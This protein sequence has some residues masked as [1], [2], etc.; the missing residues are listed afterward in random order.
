MYLCLHVSPRSKCQSLLLNQYIWCPTAQIILCIQSPWPYIILGWW[1]K[2]TRSLGESVSTPKLSLSSLS[3]SICYVRW[4]T[5]SRLL[6]LLV[7]SVS[8]AWSYEILFFTC[9]VVK[10]AVLFSLLHNRFFPLL[11][12]A[13]GTLCFIFLYQPIHSVSFTKLYL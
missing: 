1:S 4:Y 8:L 9:Y 13:Y 10:Y 12:Q 6:S 5:L 3:I 7:L 11:A 2:T